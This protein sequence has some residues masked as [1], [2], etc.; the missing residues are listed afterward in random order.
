VTGVTAT[1]CS[2]SGLSE[3]LVSRRLA[4]KFRLRL[5]VGSSS[6]PRRGL[7]PAR[8]ESDRHGDGRASAPGP[9]AGACQCRW[10]VSPAKASLTWVT[11]T[12]PRHAGCLFDRMA[13]LKPPAESLA[14]SSYVTMPPGLG[15]SSPSRIKPAVK[16]HVAQRH[17]PTGTKPAA[18]ARGAAPRDHVALASRLVTRTD[19]LSLRVQHCYH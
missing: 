8:A 13:N 14:A 6:M 12:S 2:S 7:D 11:V 19:R 4:G 16:L 5:R 1:V 15:E 10:Q 17:G 3:S 18:A 9:G